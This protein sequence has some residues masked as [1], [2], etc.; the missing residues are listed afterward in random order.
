[1]SP[2][3]GPE[4][5]KAGPRRDFFYRDGFELRNDLTLEIVRILFHVLKLE[6]VIC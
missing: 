6:S 4:L 5:N 3:F 2:F 1:M